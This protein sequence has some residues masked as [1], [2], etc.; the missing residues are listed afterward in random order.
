MMSPW[1]QCQSNIC[2]RGHTAHLTIKDRLTQQ[3]QGAHQADSPGLNETVSGNAVWIGWE[4]GDA[5]LHEDPQGHVVVLLDRG[6]NINHVSQEV[7]VAWS[8]ILPVIC[9]Y[10]LGLVLVLQRSSS[11]WCADLADRTLTHRCQTSADALSAYID[12]TEGIKYLDKLI[13]EW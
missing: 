8:F 10:I 11:S 1:R 6:L 3:N 13:T 2:A 7:L 4:G 12:A 9:N 5:A